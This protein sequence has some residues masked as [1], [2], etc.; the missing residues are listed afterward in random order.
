MKAYSLPKLNPNQYVIKAYVTYSGARQTP[1]F[2][3]IWELRE[4]QEWSL[5][6]LGFIAVPSHGQ[7]CCSEHIKIN[8]KVET[9]LSGFQPDLLLQRDFK[10]LCVSKYLSQGLIWTL[11]S[12]LI[13]FALCI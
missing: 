9:T 5:I 2:L 12:S 8:V 3:S 10:D 13:E 1:P 11:L 6:L 7:N 4:S